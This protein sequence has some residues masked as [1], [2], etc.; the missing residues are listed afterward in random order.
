MLSSGLS[1]ILSTFPF[2]SPTS[3]P[4]LYTQSYSTRSRTALSTSTPSTDNSYKKSSRRLDWS[5]TSPFSKPLISVSLWYP[6]LY[7]GLPQWPS[8]D[9]SLRAALPQIQEEGAGQARPMQGELL[10]GLREWKDGHHWHRRWGPSD[11]RQPHRL[12]LII[13]SY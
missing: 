10:R 6:L 3:Q 7:L 12:L 2:P 11:H 13:C 9:I 8:I 5:I 4:I 1:T